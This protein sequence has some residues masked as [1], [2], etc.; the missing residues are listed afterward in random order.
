MRRCKLK[1]G[2]NWQG[3]K[4]KKMAMKQGQGVHTFYLFWGSAMQF[5]LQIL[6]SIF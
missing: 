4:K 5:L 1:G 6:Q 3:A 2:V